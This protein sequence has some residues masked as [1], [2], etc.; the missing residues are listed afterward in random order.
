ML[1]TLPNVS[2]IGIWRIIG[3]KETSDKIDIQK[4]LAAY[5]SRMLFILITSKKKGGF[6]GKQ[7]YSRWDYT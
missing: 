7:F 1:E 6:A 3:N 2:F 4:N 5:R